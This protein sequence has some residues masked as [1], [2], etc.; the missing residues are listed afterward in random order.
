MKRAMTE[1]AKTARAREILNTAEKLFL[2]SG[3]RDL[4]GHSLQASPRSVY[5]CS[6]KNSFMSSSTVPIPAMPN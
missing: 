6:P 2:E 1:E 4:S 3:Y 5:A